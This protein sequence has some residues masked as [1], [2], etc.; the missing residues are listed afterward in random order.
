MLAGYT[1]GP[2]TAFFISYFASLLGALVVFLIFRHFVPSRVA[3]GLLPPSLKRVVRAIEQRPSIFLLIRVAPY[4]YNVLNAV[5]GSSSN[6]SIGTYM[7]TTAISLLKVIVHTSLGSEIRSFKDLHATN[8]AASGSGSG[9]DTGKNR[10]ITWGEIWTGIG[11]V[12]CVGLFVYLSIVARRAVNEECDHDGY[13]ALPTTVVPPSPLASP[14]QAPPQMRTLDGQPET[15]HASFNPFHPLTNPNGNS[16]SHAHTH[17][18]PG[19]GELRNASRPRSPQEMGEFT[20]PH[21]SYST[22][23]TPPRPLSV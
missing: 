2:T 14:A 18:H 9:N 7:G 3:Q 19:N 15:R 4:P 22:R 8:K 17:S 23:H 20:L 6:M 16:G 12:L 1:F 5:L 11:I 13:E 21:S 10:E